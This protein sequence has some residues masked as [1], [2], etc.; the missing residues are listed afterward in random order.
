MY[1]YMYIVRVCIGV[2]AYCGHYD[3]HDSHLVHPE[4]Y[5]FMTIVVSEVFTL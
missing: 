5:N 4:I 2:Y 3:T 1:I